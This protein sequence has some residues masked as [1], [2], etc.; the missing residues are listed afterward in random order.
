M[1]EREPVK[2]VYGVIAEANSITGKLQWSVGMWMRNDTN[3]GQLFLVSIGMDRVTDVG[4][5]EEVKVI[6]SYREDLHPNRLSYKSY[7]A[8]LFEVEARNR[9]RDSKR[10]YR[11]WARIPEM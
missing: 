9:E 6:D 3:Y 2:G 11:A 1:S 8:T 7:K 4:R 5:F 10:I